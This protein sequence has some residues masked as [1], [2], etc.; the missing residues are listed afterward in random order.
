MIIQTLYKPEENKEI[1]NFFWIGQLSESEI[2]C[3]ESFVQKRFHAKIWSYNNLKVDGAESCDASLVLPETDITKYRQRTPDAKSTETLTAFSDV[4]R[5]HVINKFGGWWFDADC[6]CLK[7]AEDFYELRKGKSLV[8]CL[9]SLGYPYIGS[10]AFYIDNKIC[11]LFIN[12]LEKTSINYNYNFPAWGIIGPQLITKV[13]HDNKLYNDVLIHN[14][15]YSIEYEK[16]DLFT[17]FNLNKLAKSYIK[18]SYLTH[19]WHSSSLKKNMEKGSLLDEL[20][21]GDYINNEMKD[22]NLSNTQNNFHK[23][24]VEISKLYHD[25]FNRSPNNR[26]LIRYVPT[27]FQQVMQ[28]NKLK[29]NY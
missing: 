15:F 13:V 24:F 26:E 28:L 14:K 29:M 8:V 2:K 21:N 1:A 9:E 25:I 11:K 3:I 23:R 27:M 16:C 17:K 4:F 19:I 6:Y 22:K 18:E 10:A 7:S 12:E 20:F 5:Y